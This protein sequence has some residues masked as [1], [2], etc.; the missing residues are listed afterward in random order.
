MRKLLLAGGIVLLSL[1]SRGQQSDVDTSRREKKVVMASVQKQRD[2]QSLVIRKDRAKK[3]GDIV[4]D[5]LGLS[6]TQREDI[7][8]INIALEQQKQMTF[9]RSADRLIVGAELQRI[10][11]QRDN[12][13]RTVLTVH[14]YDRYLKMK[15]N[16]VNP[17]KQ[18]K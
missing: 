10:E 3:I 6:Q 15:T 7:I 11:S 9:K 17:N 14:Q 18:K 5:S 13:Y 2:E 8:N 4:A 16:L 12:M 1:S